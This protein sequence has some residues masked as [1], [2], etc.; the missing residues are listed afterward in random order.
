[1]TQF[2]FYKSFQFMIE[3]IAAEGL[4]LVTME[5][6][7]Y[8]LPKVCLSLVCSFAFSFFFPTLFEHPLYMSFTFICLF[9][10]TVAAMKFIFDESL[11]KLSFCAIAGYT[12]QHLAY[13]S[14][15]VVK[16][17]MSGVGNQTMG[18]Y[19]NDSVQ[20]FSNPLFTIIY[21]FLF[22]VIYFFAYYFFASKLKSQDFK[23]PSVFGFFLV[24]VLLVVDVILNAIAVNLF[25][26]REGIILSGV[27][28]MVCCVL[29][30]FLQFEVLIRF[31]LQTQLRMNE[32]VRRL[33][34]E[35]FSAVKEATETINIKCHDLKHQIRILKQDNMISDAAASDVEKAIDDYSVFEFTG[36]SALDIVLTETNRA[37][38]KNNIRASYM[39]DGKLISF[40]T[41]EEVYS[42]FYNLFDNAVEALVDAPQEKR[43]MGLR[44]ENRFGSLVSVTVYNY[45]GDKKLEFL[46]GLPKTTK[47]RDDIHGFGLKSVKRIIDKYKGTLDITKEDEMFT[48]NILFSV[49]DL[50]VKTK[51]VQTEQNAPGDCSPT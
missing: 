37:C 32:I 30:L 43:T 28:N 25:K 39:A 46:G 11:L 22:I 17:A 6:R 1:M 21:F 20:I 31:E 27:Y 41:D 24:S 36:N 2:E 33:E 34:K 35:R 23:M 49:K 5:R 42:L 9:L 12:V 44:I 3:L 51:K 15:N 19:G 29:G 45:C 13:Q 26:T 7:K 40:M 16:V 14:Y 18:M 47:E 8:F 4:F 50:P 48:V 38:R 10:F